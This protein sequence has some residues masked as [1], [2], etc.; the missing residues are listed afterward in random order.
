MS[1]ISTYIDKD[2]E[3]TTHTLEGPIHARDIVATIE[4]YYYGQPTRNVIWDFSKAQLPDC[5]DDTLKA[6]VKAAKKYAHRRSDGKNALVLPGDL[7]FG[8]GRVF[9]A[10]AEADNYL[11]ATRSFRHL[12]DAKAWLDRSL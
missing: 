5:R 8:L 10:L 11:V 12:S 2:R 3:I 7:Q 1:S 4:E 6:I 9:E